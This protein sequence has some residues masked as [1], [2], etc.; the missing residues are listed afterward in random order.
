MS[1]PTQATPAG[2]VEA[3]ARRVFGERAASYVTSATHADPEVLARVVELALGGDT[4]IVAVG[5]AGA[6]PLGVPP[7]T[8]AMSSAMVLDV[9]TGT[10]H[11]AFALAPHAALVIG[12]D[13][14]P[15]MLDE[16]ARLRRRR[17]LANVALEVG[18][19]HDLNF[20]DAAFDA[21]T[22]RRA[23]HHFS[24]IGRA[25]PEMA[26]VLKPG[27]RLVIDDRSVPEDDFLDATMQRLDTLH[28]P[29]HVRQYRPGE[30]RGMLEAAGLV[31]DVVE[32]YTQHRPLT[33][34]TAGV[35]AADVAEIERI[36]AGLAPERRAAMNVE[37]RDGQTW[38][39]HWYV[40]VR[41]R[42]RA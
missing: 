38:T 8:P 41:A 3:Q 23:A 39:D 14:T 32:P 6:L 9:G 25:I 12:L 4:G 37:E 42:R 30:W 5:A 10:G 31:V 24:D 27:G 15:E 29:S 11:T 17:G 1:G 22:C 16:A 35:P 40:L 21:V 26:R 20:P 28:D 18:D 19:V 2:A 33:S 13:L 36:V 34:L 7:A